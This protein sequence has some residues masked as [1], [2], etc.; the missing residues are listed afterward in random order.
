MIRLVRRDRASRKLAVA[1]PLLALVAAILLNLILFVAMGKDPV[2]ALR[3]FFWEPIKSP[4]ALGELSI[5]WANP[6]K[7]AALKAAGVLK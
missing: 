5:W 2:A 3:V 7:A 1:A 6:D 4:Y